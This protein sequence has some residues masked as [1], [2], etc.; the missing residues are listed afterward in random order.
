MPV[1]PLPIT[2]GNDVLAPGGDNWNIL[3]LLFF[4]VSAMSAFS[5]AK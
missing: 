5:H 4:G 1:L 2:R 3:L